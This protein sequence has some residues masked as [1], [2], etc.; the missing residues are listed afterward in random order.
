M[1]VSGQLG[2]LTSLVD[3]KIL[4]K[5]REVCLFITLGLGGVEHSASEETLGTYFN[6]TF[7]CPLMSVLDCESPGG[8]SLCRPRRL[9]NRCSTECSF[10]CWRRLKTGGG[11]GAGLLIGCRWWWGL[12]GLTLEEWLVLEFELSGAS[13]RDGLTAFRTLASEFDALVASN[14]SWPEVGLKLDSLRVEYLYAMLTWTLNL[15]L[16]SANSV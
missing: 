3:V 15:V 9:E 4:S 2:W 5:L 13:F 14:V 6:G 10:P 8:D 12:I 7:S 16:L 1:R 11:V